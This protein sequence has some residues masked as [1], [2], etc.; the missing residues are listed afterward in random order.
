MKLFWGDWQELIPRPWGNA[1]MA[2]VAVFCGALVGVER[3]RKEKPTGMLALALVCL[4]SA[5]FTMISKVLPGENGDTSRISAQIVTGI[6][7]LG[8]GVILRGNSGITGTVTAAT[9]WA[10]AAV[11]MVAGAG[12]GGA[13]LGLSLL[14]LAVLLLVSW[15]E[16]RLLDVC[17][18]TFIR[19][20]FEPAG[21]KTLLRI[22]EVL[23]EHGVHTQLASLRPTTEGLV[24]ARL[25]YCR[26]HR[27]HREFLGRL[28]ELA[29]IK[30]IHRD[31]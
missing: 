1:V 13:A 28:A 27:H 29:E 5:V 8:A 14:I 11:G 22:E 12:Y 24:E 21:G 26:A 6:G 4:G 31:G 3:E 9:I 30:E 7:F 16:E 10:I 23:D 19:I 17:G 18:F 25:R 20:V 2:F 15:L